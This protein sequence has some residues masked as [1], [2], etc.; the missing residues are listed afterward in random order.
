MGAGDDQPGN[1]KR[2]LLAIGIGP[3]GSRAGA[4]AA[5][6][7]KVMLPKVEASAFDDT[8]R[9]VARALRLSCGRRGSTFSGINRFTARRK[10]R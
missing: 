5:T 2:P 9:P 4:N 6:I 7:L 3:L 10:M 1:I 8:A